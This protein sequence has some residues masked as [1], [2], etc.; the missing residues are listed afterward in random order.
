MINFKEIFERINLDNKNKVKSE[1]KSI[2]KGD[3]GFLKLKK[4]AK[5]SSDN[6]PDFLDYVYKKFSKDIEILSKKYDLKFDEIADIF[7]S[8]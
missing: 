3:G 4:K 2:V 8:M 1:I 7:I 6:V 5:K